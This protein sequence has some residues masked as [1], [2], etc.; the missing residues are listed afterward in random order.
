M[1]VGMVSKLW[2][3]IKHISEANKSNLGRHISE[4]NGRILD[5]FAES[6]YMLGLSTRMVKLV[7]FKF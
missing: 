6:Q 2:G 4:V 1:S 7:C 3:L 5:I